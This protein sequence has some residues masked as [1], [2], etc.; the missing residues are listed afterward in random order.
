[1]RKIVVLAPYGQVGYELVRALAPLGHVHCISRKEVDFVQFE[2][3]SQI[4]MQL[5]PDVIVNAAAWTGVDLAEAQSQAAYHI[6]ADLPA[7]LATLA[8]Q[9]NAWLVHY[10][11]DYVYSGLGEKPWQETDV[12]QP[13]TVYGQTKL[14]GDNA[15]I[16]QCAQHLIFRTSWVYAARGHNFMRTILGL[17][18]TRSQLTVVDDQRGAPTPARFIAMVTA[19]VL[20]QVLAQKTALHAG[21]YHLTTAGECSWYEFACHIIALARR[22]PLNLQLEPEGLQA[23]ST[24]Q[25]PTPAPRPLNSRLD[26]GK[27]QTTFGLCMPCW[28]DQLNLTWAE[29]LTRCI[30]Q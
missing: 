26:L 29:Y 10:S 12:S 30:S 22:H 13:K 18:Q 3:L 19:L 28:R 24:A 6:N 11:T 4:I 20:Q 27:I 23:I 25:Y 21:V 15:I 5:Q 17:A 14:A 16:A 2:R 7:L 8:T 1:M 9:L